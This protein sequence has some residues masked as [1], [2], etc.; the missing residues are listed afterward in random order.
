MV[1]EISRVFAFGDQESSDWKVVIGSVRRV[2]RMPVMFPLLM[3]MWF[4]RCVQQ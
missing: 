3:R 1:L 2:S 4:C